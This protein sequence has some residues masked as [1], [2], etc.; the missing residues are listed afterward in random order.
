MK[1]TN[2][3]FTIECNCENCGHHCMK[4]RNDNPYW[5]DWCRLHDKYVKKLHTCIDYILTEFFKENNFK[6]IRDEQ[7]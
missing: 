3:N 2:G 6:I 4:H 5:R 7:K 1:A